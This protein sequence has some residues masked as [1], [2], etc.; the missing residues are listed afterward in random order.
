MASPRTRQPDLQ[1]I[2]RSR[3]LPSEFR[4]EIALTISNSGRIVDVC[5]F[6]KESCGFDLL[7]DLSTVDNYGEEP[8]W[9]IVYELYSI[10]AGCHLRLKTHVGE[11]QSEVPSV[12]TVWPAANWH[13]REAY[14]MMGCGLEDTPI[15]AAS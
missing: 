6:A 5:R 1:P 4:G 7:L 8:R 10:T 9:T 15:C 14:D 12:S 2:W 13:E 3:V 11:E